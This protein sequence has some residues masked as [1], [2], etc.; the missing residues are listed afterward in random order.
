MVPPHGS[1]SVN[2]AFLRRFGRR[3]YP[4]T[5]RHKTPKHYFLLSDFVKATVPILYG[6]FF[7]E[8]EG[9]RKKKPSNHYDEDD[10]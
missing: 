10:E 8:N 3:Q 2:D 9:E 5:T 4:H 1:R 7:T 6:S